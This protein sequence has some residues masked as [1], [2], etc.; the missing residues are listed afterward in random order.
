MGSQISLHERTLRAVEN[1]DGEVGTE[2]LWHFQQ[3][4]DMITAEYEDQN[5]ADGHLM[6]V[7]DG[8]TWDARYYQVTEDGETVTGRS[9]G[10]VEEL[11]DGRLVVEEHWESTD[12]QGTTVL[13]EVLR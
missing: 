9:E 7:F 10:T 11:P 12:G 2:T 8:D 4:G 1:A 6:G 5:I 13:E 3:V